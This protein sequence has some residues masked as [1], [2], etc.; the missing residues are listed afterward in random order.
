MTPHAPLCATRE[1][2]LP[3]PFPCTPIYL[4]PHIHTRTPRSSAHPST[5]RQAFELAIPAPPRRPRLPRP[6]APGGCPRRLVVEPDLLGVQQREKRRVRQPTRPSGARP[7]RHGASL[8][9]GTL[10]H[11]EP[12]LVGGVQCR[13][14]L[15]QLRPG[16]ALA[17]HTRRGTSAANLERWLARPTHLIAAAAAGPPR[18]AY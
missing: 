18:V 2:N 15:L 6:G 11:V 17:K 1:R 5:H 8:G 13:Q 4:G 3:L 14:P 7:S 10:Q 16:L 9:R 12:P